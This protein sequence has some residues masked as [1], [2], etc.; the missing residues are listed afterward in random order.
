MTADSFAVVPYVERHDALAVEGVHFLDTM[1]QAIKVAQ[2]CA[3]RRPGVQVLA[4]ERH[5]DGTIAGFHVLRVL[6][7]APETFSEP[8]AEREPE[9]RAPRTDPGH[10]EAG[11]SR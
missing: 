2:F 3:A 6:G 9:R 4:V 5:D 11:A 1:I 7:R 10:Y 8:L